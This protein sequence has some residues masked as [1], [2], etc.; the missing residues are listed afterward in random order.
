MGKW[1]ILALFSF[2]LAGCATSGGSQDSGMKEIGRSERFVAYD[3]GTVKDLVTGLMWASRDNGGPISWRGAKEYC[4][5]Y[6]GG[7]YKDWRMPTT[8]ELK[9]IYNP[10]IDNPHPLGEGCKGV[11][12][13][14]RFIQLSCCPVWSWDGISEVETFFHFDR[15]PSAWRDKSLVKNHPRALPVRGDR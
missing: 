4:R 8:E 2:L 12:H 11:C 1:V 5:N 13:I 9:A 3:N 7:G 10:R 6:K 15:G 14:T